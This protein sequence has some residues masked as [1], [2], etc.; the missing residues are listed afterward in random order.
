[1]QVLKAKRRLASF[2]LFT[3]LA[4]LLLFSSA[5]LVRRRTV[6]PAGKTVDQPLL[7]ASKQQLMERVRAVADPL[8]SFVMK[9]DMSPSIGSLYGG[10]VT[11]YPT[12]TGF[13]IFR[14]PSDIRVIGLDPVIHGTAFDMLA[15]GNEF[16][17]SIP[18]KNQFIEGRDD[19]PADSPNKLE[20]LRPSAF[21]TSLLIDPPDPG[22]ITML[23]DD[24]D[25]TKSVYILMIV[26]HDGDVYWLA[27]N[28]YF[29]RHTLAI[30]R[31]K[32]FN[33]AGA[34]TSQTK[35]GDWQ[36]FSGVPFP[37]SIDIQRPLDGYELV[38]KVTDMKMNSGEVTAD[39][40]VL[41]QP[42]NAQLKVLK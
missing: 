11:D 31:Q 34:T 29:D 36:T 41:P 7:N 23:E 32:T 42:P 26:H 5:C 6:V 20:N 30:I 33:P 17:V 4:F 40:F 19:L 16:K 39:K 15:M 14:R 13:V 21:R 25:E 8:H 38:L 1:M 28:L 37:T 10:Q 2:L 24:T 27:R 3:E 9:V 12:I 35:Y 22:E 18:P